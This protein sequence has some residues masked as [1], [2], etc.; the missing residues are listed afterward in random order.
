MELSEKKIRF[1][2]ALLREQNQSGCR[3]PAHDLLRERAFPNAPRSGPGSLAFAYEAVPF[4][5]L[6]LRDFRD[7]Q[8]L[9][10]FVQKGESIADPEWPWS[11]A[12][13]FQARLQEARRI[14]KQQVTSDALPSTIGPLTETTSSAK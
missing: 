4:T 11:S 7:L 13:A 10:E 9:D 8:Q 2:T 1:L 14:W 3:G 6:I 12:E 5:S